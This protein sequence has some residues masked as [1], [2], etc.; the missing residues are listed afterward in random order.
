MEP[1][2]FGDLARNR[3]LICQPGKCLTC[4]YQQ[5]CARTSGKERKKGLGG[6]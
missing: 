6:Y 1:P 4:E 3:S 5:M 2:C